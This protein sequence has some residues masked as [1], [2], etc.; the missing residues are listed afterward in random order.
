MLAQDYLKCAPIDINLLNG[1]HI[2]VKCN[3]YY[4]K[5]VNYLIDYLFPKKCPQRRI[6][7]P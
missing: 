7:I 4:R 3:A 6:S 5:A 2:C 1:F